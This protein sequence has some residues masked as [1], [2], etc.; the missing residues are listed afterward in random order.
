MSDDKVRKTLTIKTNTT[1]SEKPTD[2]TRAGSRA[3]KAKLQQHR[4]AVQKRVQ[5]VKKQIRQQ[6]LG[7]K[8]VSGTVKTRAKSVGLRNYETLHQAFAPCPSG[9]E[10]ALHEELVQLGF[11]D[12]AV[13]RAGCRFKT[14]WSGI[15]KANLYSRIATRVLVQLA[16]AQVANEDDILELAKSVEWEQYFG[17][18]HTLRLDTSAIRSPMQSLQ[19]CNLKAKDGICDRLREK[20]GARP[21]IDTVRP[22]ARVQLFLDENSATLYLDSTGESLFKRGWRL[23]KGQAPLRENLAAGLLSLAGWSPEHALLDPFCGSATILIEAAFKASNMAPGIDRPFGFMRLRD[24]NHKMWQDM[25]DEARDKV[26]HCTTK[27]YGFDID[28]KSIRAAQANIRRAGLDSSLIQLRTGDACKLSA[29]IHTGFIITNPPYG[30]RMQADTS[31]WPEWSANLKQNYK[32]WSVN[33]ISS[34]MGLPGNMRLK[35]KSRTPVFNGAL[36]C[37]LFGFDIT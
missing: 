35:A 27:L 31:L 23:D 22:D 18:E 24:H 29:P 13:A 2:R 26:V 36:D 11:Q 1:A 33:V 32:G 4:R 21:S 37:R 20:E 16:H 34:D 9:L 7:Q 28:P 12:V 6:K 15:M 30:E 14:N 25:K 5:S 8:P 3:H 10:N 17:P 19:Y